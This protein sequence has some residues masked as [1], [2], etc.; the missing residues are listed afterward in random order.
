MCFLN[1]LNLTY[2][3]VKVSLTVCPYSTVRFK[4]EFERVGGLWCL[5]DTPQA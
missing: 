4:V 3:I 1:T 5:S 2:A